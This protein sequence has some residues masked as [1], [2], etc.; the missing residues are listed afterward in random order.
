MRWR[1][2]PHRSTDEIGRTSAG[3]IH[4]RQKRSQN[5]APVLVII[6]ENFLVFSRKIITSTG[7]Y[8]CCAPG[9]SAPV[10]VKHRSPKFCSNGESR[11]SLLHRQEASI[12]WCDLFQP[13]FGQKMP[14]MISL[15]DVL[16][17][18]KQALLASRDVKNSS[19]ICGSNSQKVFTLG[20]GC[21]LPGAFSG[22]EKLTRSSLKGFLTAPFFLKKMGAF[23]K[24]LRENIDEEK[25]AIEYFD[26]VPFMKQ[27]QTRKKRKERDK[28]KEPKESKKERQEGRKKRRKE[29]ERE[30]EREREKERERERETE[31]EKEKKRDAKKG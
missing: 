8:R 11:Q 16:E 7:F 30:R 18:L 9:A 21:W 1:G 15:H 22:V 25:P 19:Q 24:Q 13:K 29:R 28:N 31:K 4:Q 12:T 6:S 5:L 14:K 2:L 26:V 20:D 27:K 23:C 3:S 10:V 17:P